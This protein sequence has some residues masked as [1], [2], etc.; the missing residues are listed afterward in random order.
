MAN[1]DRGL[2]LLDRQFDV[3]TA[4]AVLALV[5]DPIA[6]LHEIR[7]VL[8][9]GGQLVVEVLNLVYLPRR[10]AV[11]TG[12]LPTHTT[13]H[14]WEGGH[15]HNFT[16]P[17]LIRLLRECGFEVE[18]VTGSGVLTSLRQWWPGLLLGNVIA[19][20]RRVDG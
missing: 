5:L 7:R 19:S 3:V 20:A 11:L 13:C 8:R 6:Q 4:I 15:L 12:R 14:G 9:P 16:R 1:V 2:P 17:A 10:L 18:A